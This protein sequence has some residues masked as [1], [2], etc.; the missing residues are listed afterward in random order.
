MSSC[1][2][3]T[4]TPTLPHERDMDEGGRGRCWGVELAG[5][6]AGG[7]GGWWWWFCKRAVGTGPLQSITMSPPLLTVDVFISRELCL[8][9]G[10]GGRRFVRWGLL[11][12]PYVNW[13][14]LSK[15][16]GKDLN[17]PGVAW[18]WKSESLSYYNNH[19]VT[20]AL[21]LFGESSTASRYIKIDFIKKKKIV[22][23]FFAMEYIVVVKG[24]GMK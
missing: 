16:R 17:W 22:S 12:R 23:L 8:L 24:F 19:F 13:Y 18:T 11:S 7:G 14:L 15:S 9:G 2:S 10:E 4:L 20:Q 1:S 5:A 3:L 6:G 21:F